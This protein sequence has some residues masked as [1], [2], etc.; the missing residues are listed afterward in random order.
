MSQDKYKPLRQAG[1]QEPMTCAE[2]KRTTTDTDCFKVSTEHRCRALAHFEQCSACQFWVAI[3]EEEAGYDDDDDTEDPRIVAMLD[4]DLKAI[5]NPKPFV[6][7]NE[8]PF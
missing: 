4:N 5:E 6:D 3:R 8:C 1:A 2:F 7:N